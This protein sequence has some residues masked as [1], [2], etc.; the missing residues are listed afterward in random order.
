MISAMKGHLATLQFAAP[1][2]VSKVDDQVCVFL[3]KF[4]PSFSRSLSHAFLSF[5]QLLDLLL[6]KDGLCRWL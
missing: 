2:T 5:T 6:L 3:L 1:R 4:L